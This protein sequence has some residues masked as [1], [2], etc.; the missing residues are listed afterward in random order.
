MSSLCGIIT[1]F[2]RFLLIITCCT[3]DSRSF[4]TLAFRF[5]R[6]LA[7][8]ARPKPSPSQSHYRRSGPRAESQTRSDRIL[9]ANPFSKVTDQCF[10]LSLSAFFVISQKLLDPAAINRYALVRDSIAQA[11]IFLGRLEGNRWRPA[12]TTK[13]NKVNKRSSRSFRGN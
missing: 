3:M 5:L 1:L 10:R 2:F 6:P 4:S 7:A 9:R 12:R 11:R 8:H 13:C